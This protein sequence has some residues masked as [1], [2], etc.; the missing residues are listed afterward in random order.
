MPLSPRTR[1]QIRPLEAT[2]LE[3]WVRMRQALWPYHS[4]DELRAD[5]ERI[6]GG[7]A[8]PFLKI[9]TFVAEDAEGLCGFIEA[10]LHPFADGC[11]TSPVGYIEGWYVAADLR[12][13]GIGAKLVR[14]AENW[15]RSEGCT[16]M[17]SDAHADNELSRKAHKAL[18]YKEKRPVVRFRK[19]L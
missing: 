15:A 10:S 7:D 9:M 11:T 4:A 5:A 16:E 12:G 2:D 1:M 3:A 19:D 8:A 18:G 14:A 17:A 13:E 6:L